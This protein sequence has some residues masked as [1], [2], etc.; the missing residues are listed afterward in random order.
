M[1]TKKTNSKKNTS[2]KA[3]P[4]RPA[5]TKKNENIVVEETSKGI[6]NISSQD[7]VESAVTNAAEAT[8]AP[9][10]S[11]SSNDIK[12]E[13]SY[14]KHI[15]QPPEQII[16]TTEEVVQENASYN[17]TFVPKQNNNDSIALYVIAALGI[18]M[19]AW[20]LVL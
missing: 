10:T 20:L 19:L 14:E 7:A 3:S 15:E 18:M 8:I 2:K 13:V 5:K 4:K 12:E 1:A 6:Y 11:L 16:T 9:I 17:N